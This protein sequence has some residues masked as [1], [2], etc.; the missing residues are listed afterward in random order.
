[1]VTFETASQAAANNHSPVSC[2]VGSNG[3][4]GYVASNGF[5]A[6][7]YCGTWITL[8]SPDWVKDIGCAQLEGFK[9]VL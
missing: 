8:A 7:Y 6:M 1:M 4:W 5:S 9:L 3:V 2:P